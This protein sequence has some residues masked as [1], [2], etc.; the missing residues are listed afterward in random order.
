MWKGCFVALVTPY[1]KDGSLDLEA[2]ERIVLW[3]LEAGTEGFVVLGSTAEAALLELEE[4][5]QLLKSVVSLAKGRAPIIAGVSS[6][7][8][9]RCIEQIEWAMDIGADACMATPPYYV[10]PMPRG[11]SAHFQALNAVG[12]PLIVYNH[13]GR[14]G[15]NLSSETLQKLAQLANVVAIKESGAGAATCGDLPVFCGDDPRAYEMLSSGSAGSISV[16]ANAFPVQWRAFVD[17]ALAK[18]GEANRFQGLLS[19]FN[20]D[21]NPVPVKY[22]MEQIGLCSA[23]VRLPLLELEES[24]KAAINEA[25]RS[26]LLGEFLEPLEK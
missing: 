15:V 13:P 14:T 1:K 8:T 26:E 7:S 11:C 21:T 19:A 22:V 5:E 9:K 16:L 3:H 2:F 25:L 10:K 24:S 12:A 23:A 4:K 17:A 18:E 20:C 6:P